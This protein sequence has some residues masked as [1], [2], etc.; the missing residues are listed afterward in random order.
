MST[1]RRKSSPG[2]VLGCVGL[3]WFLVWLAT[4]GVVAT[5]SLVTAA[6]FGSA[7]AFGFM[8]RNRP[9]RKAKGRRRGPA[10]KRP[11]KTR[12]Q[13]TKATGKAPVKPPPGTRQCSAACRRSVKPKF[14]REGKLS[15]DCAC[16]GRNHGMYVEGTKANIMS[17]PIPKGNAQA[18]RKA[19]TRI[20]NEKSAARRQAA[21]D[22]A[23]PVARGG[24]S[25]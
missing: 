13:R 20:R 22:R 16:R 14:D 19:E 25:Q 2:V 4:T 10:P 17:T 3:V 12:T 23:K 6:G 5:I 8:M 11:G 21:M 9:G 7:S 1:R 24:S 18:Q 15:C